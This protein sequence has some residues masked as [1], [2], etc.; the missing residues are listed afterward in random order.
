M[1]FTSELETSLAPIKSLVEALQSKGTAVAEP[2]PKPPS[3]ED[4]P[5]AIGFIRSS[6]RKMDGLINAILKL[7]REGRRPLKPE[8]IDL[9]KLIG[10]AVAAVQ[11]QLDEAGGRVELA[12]AVPPINSDRL[13]L[14]QIFG[15]LLDNAVKYRDDDRPLTS[16]S[17]HA[18]TRPAGSRS[19]SPTMAA[20]SRSRTM[21]ASS[22]CSGVPERRTSRARAS[23]SPMSARWCAISAATSR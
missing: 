1:G 9:G 17:P 12:L 3:T 6:T 15:N 7:S 2:R 22:S 20:A 8:R 13:S 14:E 21:S 11:H 23:A 10:Q 4:L 5:E 16:A 18:G 19:S